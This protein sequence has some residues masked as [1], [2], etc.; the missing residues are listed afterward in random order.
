MNHKTQW[1]WYYVYINYINI[2]STIYLIQRACFILQ[3]MANW[4]ELYHIMI[5]IILYNK[6]SKTIKMVLL[7]YSQVVM[8]I[9]CARCND[10]SIL[11]LWTSHK[12][13][14]QDLDHKRIFTSIELSYHFA[15]FVI[16][17]FLRIW[18]SHV[19]WTYIM[20]RICVSFALFWGRGGLSV[21]KKRLVLID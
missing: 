4:L 11:W 6:K 12:H 16:I 5:I 14:I 19:P 21:Q 18:Y 1:Y 17:N 15:L 8:I 20:M 2:I 7:M 13:I 3:N 9:S 10:S